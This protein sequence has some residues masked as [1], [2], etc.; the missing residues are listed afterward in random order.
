M[1][2][3]RHKRPWHE[4]LREWVWPRSGWRRSMQYVVYRLQRLPDTPYRIAA[5]VACGTAVSFTP[6]MGLHLLLALVLAFAMRANIVA[7]ALGTLVGNPWTFPFIWVFIYR[8]GGALLG[9]DTSVPLKDRI[10]G[11]SLMSD[12]LAVLEPVLW[13]MIAGGI[14]I[15][16]LVWLLTYFPLRRLIE[17]RR[18][19]RAKRFES[20]S[21]EKPYGR[22]KGDS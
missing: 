2:K 11:G 18:A 14:P 15:A 5:G 21:D 8:F 19:K 3:R 4:T 9:L 6:F 12:P 16:I 13:P 20:A 17:R 22:R 1:F 10:G 7:S